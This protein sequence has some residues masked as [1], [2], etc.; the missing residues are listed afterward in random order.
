MTLDLEPDH[1]ALFL[2]FDG[3][4]VEIA[5]R[6][7]AIVVPD[8]LVSLLAA[9]A[10]RVGG[11]LAVI[12]GRSVGTLDGYLRP[13]R[14]PAAGIHGLE[15][16][17]DPRAAVVRAP[18]PASLTEVRDALARSHLHAPGIQ[19]EDKGASFAVHYRQA[20]DQG[21]AVEATL[22]ALIAPHP[23]LDILNGKMVYEVKPLG[24]SK[25][26]AITRFLKLPPFE[27]RMPVFIGDDVTDEDGIAAAERL[28]GVGIKVGEGVTAASRRLP[29]V[30]AVHHWLGTML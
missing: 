28:G 19:I 17:A 27:G 9:L 21:P 4:L 8:G 16:R 1:I 26:I 6:P 3:T 7:D 30:S 15:W 12:S 10:A 14:F 13:A 11:A 5:P 2:D 25:A 24:A 20:P 29:T 22:R 18:P 23:D